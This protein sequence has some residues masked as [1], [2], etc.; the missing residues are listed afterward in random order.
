MLFFNSWRLLKTGM[1][2]DQ[3]YTDKL[4]KIKTRYEFGCC[5]INGR[6][7]NISLLG[8]IFHENTNHNTCFT[9]RYSYFEYVVKVQLHVF[10]LNLFSKALLSFWIKLH[11][12]IWISGISNFWIYRYILSTMVCLN[13]FLTI[14][15]K[16]IVNSPGRSYFYLIE[17]IYWTYW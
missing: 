12:E 9:T 4:Y 1:P 2:R 17:K 11:N 10:A 3:R 7:S 5:H 8:K 6:V 13:Q 15:A 14:W 16:E